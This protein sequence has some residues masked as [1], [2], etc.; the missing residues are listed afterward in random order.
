MKLF[1]LFT[2]CFCLLLIPPRNASAQNIGLV[3]KASTSGVG[4]EFGYRLSDK[5]ILK[6]GYETIDLNYSSTFT[7]SD[8]TI[9]ASGSFTT[10][11]VS[12][13]MDYQLF[14]FL[15]VSTGILLNNTAVTVSGAFA[16]DYVWGD[17]VISKE[18]MGAIEWKITPQYALSPYLGIGFGNNLIH[19]RRVSYSFEVGGIFQGSPQIDI[20]SDGILAPNQ[21]PDFNQSGILENQISKYRFY[22]TIKV[23]LG[24]NIV[25]FK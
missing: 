8:F 1:T 4:G 10:G 18:D 9:D 12:F 11:N 2:F 22:P 23:Q 15:Y 24:I 16:E 19:S 6:A 17:V 3:A 20:S 13:L 21:D 5:F 7:E 25:R 14:N